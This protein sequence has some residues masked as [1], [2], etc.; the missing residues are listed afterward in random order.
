MLESGLAY[1]YYF[2]P[3]HAFLSPYLSAN[4]AYQLLAWH[5]RNAVIINGDTITSDSL[6][7]MGAYVGL[8]LA[9]KRNSHLSFFGEA[10]FGGTVFVGDTYQGFYNDVFHDFGYF[11]V[12]VGLSL[13]F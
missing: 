10:G 12:K 8:G 3:A 13:K 1:R 7:A 2:T 4:A 9:I 6:D 11:S 5:Y